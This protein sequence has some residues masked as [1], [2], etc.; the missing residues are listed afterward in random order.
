LKKTQE[1]YKKKINTLHVF[2]FSLLPSIPINKNIGI[3]KIS[4]QRYKTNKS[5][6]ANKINKIKSN[7][8]KTFP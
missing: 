1:K 5:R 8:N 4:K 7:D 3:N 2:F 6:V